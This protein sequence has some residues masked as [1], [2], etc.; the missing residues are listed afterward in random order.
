MEVPA[1]SNVGG[2]YAPSPAYSATALQASS[3]ATIDLPAGDYG[4][5]S[6][7]VASQVNM[8]FGQM[9]QGQAID[10]ETLKALIMLLVLQMLMNGGQGEQG[11]EL[12]GGLAKAFQESGNSE[13]SMVAMQASSMI[14]IDFAGGD[15]PA[16]SIAAGAG[17]SLDMVG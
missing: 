4:P 16:M 15:M 6:I 10:P 7:T 13:M 1:I 17:A 14:Q 9:T 2:S 3:A 5:M 12:L 8:V 11:Q